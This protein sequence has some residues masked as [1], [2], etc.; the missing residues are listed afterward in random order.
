MTTK[1]NKLVRDKIPEYIRSKGGKPLYHT[2]DEKE[3]WEKLKGKLLE[4]F[5]EF[6]E[7]ESIEEFADLM[8]V[9]DAIADWKKF[10]KKDVEGVRNKKS[11]ERGLF[12]DRIV[13]DKS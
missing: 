5:E 1:Y 10:D 7:A 4:E 6:K 3:Y 11:Q 2:A 13:L 12:K 9:I 8:E